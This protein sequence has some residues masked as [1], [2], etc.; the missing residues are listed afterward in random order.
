LAVDTEITFIII[1]KD[2][3]KTLDSG[4]PGLLVLPV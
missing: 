2:E 3:K 4:D 1:P